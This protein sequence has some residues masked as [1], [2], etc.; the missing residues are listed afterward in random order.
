MSNEEIAQVEDFSTRQKPLPIDIQETTGHELYTNYLDFN[1]CAM[2]HI[3]F[4][5]EFLVANEISFLPDTYFEDL[6]F[7]P[8]CYLKANKC[9]K[10]S[11]N[12][13]I[14]RRRAG[15]V[16]LGYFNKKKAE[17]LCVLINQNWKLKA[18]MNSKKLNE[19]SNLF[20][21]QLI[22][23]LLYS[24][25]HSEIK[26]KERKHML[27]SIK[28]EINAI[29]SLKVSKQILKNTLIRTMPVL[30]TYIRHYIGR[31]W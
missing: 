3:L 6:L 14:Y 26:Y 25:S 22:Q 19:K 9:I 30:F 1:N 8:E 12:L 17:S 18:L 24:L 31:S 21:A 10:A 4:K 13:Y 27:N 2:W 16:S 23:I 11:W 29:Y 7:T 20:I 28:Q 5:R 15:S